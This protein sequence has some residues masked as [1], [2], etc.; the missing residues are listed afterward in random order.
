MEATQTPSSPDYGDRDVT[1]SKATVDRIELPE[2]APAA[3]PEGGF[4]LDRFLDR[5]MS[6]LDFNARVLELAEDPE[7]YLLERVNFLSIFLVLIR[8]LCFTLNRLALVGSLS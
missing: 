4:S 7:L 1:P 8:L 2:F 6:W 3:E 5:E